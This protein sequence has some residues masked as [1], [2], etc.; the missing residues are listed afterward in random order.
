MPRYSIRSSR[1]VQ[2]AL[3]VCLL[4][5]TTSACSGC[6]QGGELCTSS[7]ECFRNEVCLEGVCRRVCNADRDCLREE[8]CQNGFCMPGSAAADEGSSPDRAALADIRSDGRSEGGVSDI[9]APD[10]TIQDRHT[11]RRPDAVADT[12]SVVDHLPVLDSATGSDVLADVARDISAERPP[13]SG[14]MDS[15]TS[16]DVLLLADGALDLVSGDRPVDS[17]AAGDRAGPTDIVVLDLSPADDTGPPDRRADSSGVGDRPGDGGCDC[18]CLGGE[19][20]EGHCYTVAPE[21][22]MPWLEAQ[23]Y[24]EDLGLHLVTPQSTAE[25]DFIRIIVPSTGPSPMFWIGLTDRAQEGSWLWRSGEPLAETSWE[26]TQP[27]NAVSGEDCA[28]GD[29]SSGLW[30]DL[31]CDQ[32]VEFTVCEI[33]PGVAAAVCGNGTVDP[34]EACDD[35]NREDGDSCSA[36]CTVE[37]L[38]APEDLTCDSAGTHDDHCYIIATEASWEDGRNDCLARNM[39]LVAVS[40]AEEQSYLNAR[41]DAMA[42]WA[43]FWIGLND[44]AVE[45]TFEWSNGEE[46][47]Y[48]N[49][50][51]GEPNDYQSHEDCTEIVSSAGD[52]L[53]NDFDC[54]ETTNQFPV[55]ES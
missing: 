47:V 53:W 48:T 34:G 38:C 27:D 54:L 42:S 19:S 49:W 41:A 5:G 24:C 51:G 2:A 9:G 29:L 12:S 35:S 45:G 46:V 20:F 50:K 14:E 16:V 21:K 22:N 3:A 31:P 10:R 44:R 17:G 15:A 28:V 7:T 25:T 13:D 36:S 1:Y 8:T 6:E 11:D 39:D 32:P 40:S 26:P 52:W 4:G 55:C 23:R 18:A 43:S 30:N 37:C 33:E